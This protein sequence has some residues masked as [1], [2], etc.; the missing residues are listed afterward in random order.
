MNDVTIGGKYRIVRPLGRG[1]MGEVHLALH[2]TLGHKVA[3]KALLS[4][5]AR[6]EHAVR[7]FVREA[8]LLARL[9]SDHAP[10]VFDLGAM[11]DGRPFLVMEYLEGCDL[12]AF[13]GRALPVPTAVDYVLQAIDAIAEAHARGMVHRDLKPANLFLHTRC[14]GRRLIKVLDFGLSKISGNP[15]RTSSARIIGSPAYMSPEQL[16]SPGDV[17]ARADIWSLGVV[18]YELLAG[19]LPFDDRIPI[20]LLFRVMAGRYAPVRERRSEVPVDLEA[21]VHRCLAL[22]P[23]LRPPDVA[24]L[25][26][27]LAPFGSGRAHRSVR[28]AA[29]LLSRSPAPPSGLKK[30]AAASLV[31]LAGAA[32]TVVAACHW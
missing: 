13:R 27:S 1:G 31:M 19:A 28:R 26:A 14:D 21:I 5:H 6:D 11:Q 17:D 22:E 10:R 18:L 32:A 4:K 7:C 12:S 24:E 2:E 8:R 20:R 3:L 16:D 15:T 29:R 30:I 23:A 9:E 25:A